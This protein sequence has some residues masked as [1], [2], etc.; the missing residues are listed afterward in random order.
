MHLQTRP[1]AHIV[2]RIERLPRVLGKVQLCFGLLHARCTS[3]TCLCRYAL[4]LSGHSLGAGTA[5]VAVDMLHRNPANFPGITSHAPLSS[6]SCFAVA[7]PPA[8]S[9]EL[10][11]QARRHTAS[12]I[13][14]HD[15][16]ARASIANFQQ[17][18]VRP[19]AAD[20]SVE[21]VPCVCSCLS[22]PAFVAHKLP[23]RS[24]PVHFTPTRT[25]A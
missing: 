10:A 8:F 11:R 17:L 23:A 14:G 5:A 21:A 19:C 1:P 25:P 24:A 4:R 18:Q 13:M 12:L 2:S 7:P 6:I 15:V 16:V 22:G 20:H 3:L 9:L